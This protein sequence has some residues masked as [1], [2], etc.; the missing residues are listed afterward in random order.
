MDILF[1]NINLISPEDDLNESTDIL[2]SDGIIRKIGKAGSFKKTT[3]E[4][5]GRNKVCIPGLFDMHVHFRDPGQ[6]HKEDLLTGSESAANG[7]FTGV[8]CMPNTSPPL[9]SPV[10]VKNILDRAKDFLVDVNIAACATLKSEGEILSPILTLNKAGINAFTDD[11]NPVANPEVLR[12]VLEYTAQTGSVFVQHC[13]DRNLSDGGVMNEGLIST[14]TGLKGIPEVSETAI[15]ARDILL[16]EY[17]RNSRYHIQHVSCGNSIDLVRNAKK[18]NINVTCEVCPHHFIL[19]EKA[20]ID[21]DT[22]AKMNP[23]LRTM[24]DVNM[25]I[26]GLRDDT[27]DVICTD[28]A[29]HSE[30]EKGQGFNLAPFGITGLETCVG[31]VYTYLVKSGVI[32]FEKMIEK[33]SVNPRKILGLESIQI[34]EGSKANLTVLNTKAEWIVDKNK[35]KSKSRNTPFHGSEL[36]CK[37]YCVINNNR[38]Y[39]SDL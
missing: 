12:R 37:P 21:Y 38:I 6:T 33:M 22:N 15:I 20:C 5:S 28:H 14:I 13:E 19:N 23:P 24:K 34:K 7:G 29:P 9:D 10:I 1:R 16:T 11:G 2:I 26:E 30:Y 17:V 35:F 8:L 3:R 32:S 39:F 36:F 18:K 25:I 31:L 4:I 27:I